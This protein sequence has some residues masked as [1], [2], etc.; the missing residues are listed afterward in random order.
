[1]LRLDLEQGILRLHDVVRHYIRD[2][3][4]DDEM[5]QFETQLVTAM[6]AICTGSNASSPE[7]K[8]FLPLVLYCAS[9]AHRWDIIIRCLSDPVM[10]EVIPPVTYGAG[11]S[12]GFFHGVSRGALQPNQLIELNSSERAA[13]GEAIATAFASSARRRM[14]RTRSFPRPWPVHAQKLRAESGEGFAEYRDA[15]YIFAVLAGLAAQWALVTF[16]HG[17]FVHIA[18][19]FIDSNDDIV[20]FL[21][22]LYKCGASETDLSGALE[23]N[24][25]GPSLDLWRELQARTIVSST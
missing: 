4:L 22:Y 3:V 11:Y 2:A 21:D 14:Q 19:K 6:D 5:Q 7:M 10:F 18:R 8:F 24:L 16:E 25:A 23:D 9:R 13:V 20:S 17:S 1:M 15:F 12:P